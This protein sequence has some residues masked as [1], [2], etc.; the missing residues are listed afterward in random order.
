MTADLRIKLT[1]IATNL[2]SLNLDAPEIDDAIIKLDNLAF[3]AGDDPA[4]GVVDEVIRDL[5]GTMEHCLSADDEGVDYAVSRQKLDALTTLGLMEKVGRGRWVPTEAGEA[6][7][8]L[9]AA[10]PAVPS[11]PEGMVLVPRVPTIAMENAWEQHYGN[12]FK[13]RYSSMLAAATPKDQPAQ[14]VE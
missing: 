6:F 12:T 11:V 4:R 14:G 5:R 9:Q 10:Q 2:R 13:G 3:A 8:S 7:A 1:N